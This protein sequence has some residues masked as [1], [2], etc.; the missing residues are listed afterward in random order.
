LFTEGREQTMTAEQRVLVH[1]A[2]KATT[3]WYDMSLEKPP[4]R[5]NYMDI[6][7]QQIDFCLSCTLNANACER[8]NGNGKVNKRGGPRVN[9]D[10]EELKEALQLKKTNRELCLQFGMSE[11]TLCKLKKKIKEENL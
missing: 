9:V 6:P 2:L 5:K 8:C 4:E 1:S 10:L 3:P 7:Q 11:P